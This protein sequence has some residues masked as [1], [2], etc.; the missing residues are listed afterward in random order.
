MLSVWD[1]KAPIDSQS[2]WAITGWRSIT[3]DMKLFAPLGNHLVE[4]SAQS[5]EQNGRA[6]RSLIGDEYGFQH[7]V[8]P[9]KRLSLF[10]CTKRYLTF[11][12]AIYRKMLTVSCVTD[13]TLSA[14]VL[15]AQPV[16]DW[17]FRRGSLMRNRAVL[18][19]RDMT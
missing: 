8:S 2:V 16:G 1:H 18:L 12:V 9:S 15:L 7:S 17:R 10:S 11:S 3:L 4:N 5:F 14:V 19:A 13:F 6:H